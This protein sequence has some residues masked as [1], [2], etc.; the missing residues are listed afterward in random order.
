MV[1]QVV[2][3]PD[4]CI[5]PSQSYI[6]RA[7]HVSEMEIDNRNIPDPFLYDTGRESKRPLIERNGLRV[8]FSEMSVEDDLFNL[9]GQLFIIDKQTWNESNFTCSGDGQVAKEIF[10]CTA[11]KTISNS[12]SPLH[13]EKYRQPPSVMGLL[14]RYIYHKS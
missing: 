5:C 9:T 13:A 14:T 6:C 8:L 10:M 3:E 4:G 11:G 12:D 7:S 2:V 1:V